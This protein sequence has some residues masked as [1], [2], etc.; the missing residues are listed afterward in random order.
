V[1]ALRRVRRRARDGGFVHVRAADPCNLVGVVLPG[2]RV[3]SSLGQTLVFQDGDFRGLS[4]SMPGATPPRT[5]EGRREGVGAPLL[6]TYA[7][8]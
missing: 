2:P 5:G 4:G 3:P 1:D 6:A 7:S 8:S